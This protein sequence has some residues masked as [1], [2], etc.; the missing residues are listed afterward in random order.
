MLFYVWFV[1]NTYIYFIFSI[2]NE[3]LSVAI[4]KLVN[5][6]LNLNFSTEIL[7]IYNKPLESQNRT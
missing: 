4:D 7:E 1:E 3:N 5:A 6:S 2:N